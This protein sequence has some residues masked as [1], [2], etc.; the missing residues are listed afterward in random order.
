VLPSGEILERV[1]P[2]NIEAEQAVLGAVLLQNTALNKA[3]E[4]LQAA[5]F[6]KAA[7]QKIFQAMIKMSTAGDAIDLVTLR[8]HL[9]RKERIDAVGGAAYLSQL[10]EVVP[11]AANIQHYIRIVKEKSVAR[12]LI[13]AATEI[14]REGFDEALGTEELLELAE[15][16]IFEISGE[17]IRQGFVGIEHI[18]KNSF[19]FIESLY[20]KKELITGIPS[21]FADLDT[22]TSGFQPSDLIIVAGR[23]S[24]GKTALCLNIAQHVGIQAKKA[25]AIFS[26]EMSKEQLVIRMLCAE[27]RVDAHRLRTGQLKKT[28]WGKLT[29]AAGDLSDAP[30]FID[31]TP[32]ISILEM[33]AKS[34]RLMLEHGLSMVIVDYLQLMRGHASAERREQEISEISRSLKALAKELNIPVVALSQLNRSVESRNDKRP[35][36]ADLRESGAIEQDADVILF[37]S[38]DEVYKETEENKGKAEI[39]IG[40]QRNGPTGTVAL[41]FERRFTLFQNFSPRD[42]ERDYAEPAPHFS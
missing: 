22:K 29:N 30:I 7:H 20:E 36:L 19:E 42:Q 37:V 35:M 4:H 10:T 40:K 6:Y 16:R 21:G 24:M 11:T 3:M 27:A 9:L 33:R 31:D 2:Q 32:A 1:P 13:N 18:I 17:N 14:V 15:K 8:D 28:D 5:D 26:L 38:R 12:R 41:H 34:R 25:V 23:P 39:I